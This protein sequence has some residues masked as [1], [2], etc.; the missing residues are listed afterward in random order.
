VWSVSN[1]RAAERASA[2]RADEPL[3]ESELAAADCI[4][5]D[6]FDRHWHRHWR[7]RPRSRCCGRRSAIMRKAARLFGR[8]VYVTVVVSGC[9]ALAAMLMVLFEGCAAQPQ[10][11]YSV[12]AATP[13]SH[14]IMVFNACTGDVEF[15]ALNVPPPLPKGDEDDNGSTPEHESPKQPGVF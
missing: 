10:T 14:E 1:V 8:L 9:L 13:A 6:D 11:C 5:N 4:L 15:R 2:G 7:L 3:G 12:I